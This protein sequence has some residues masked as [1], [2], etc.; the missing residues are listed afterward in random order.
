MTTYSGSNLTERQLA[1]R[2][3]L[4]PARFHPRTAR[5]CQMAEAMRDVYELPDRGSAALAL[6]RLCSWMTHSNVPEMKV[7]ARTLRKEREGVLN[8]W[9]RG[10]TN[11]ILEGLNSVIQSVKRAARGFRN[12]GYFETMIFLRLG[13][14][15]FSAQLAVSSATH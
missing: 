10:S 4:D 11:A 7:V 9:R 15:D 13:R 3:E 2:A 8:W 5:A 14:L 1:K 6:D 12:T